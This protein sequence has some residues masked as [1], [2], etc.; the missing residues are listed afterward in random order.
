MINEINAAA[1]AYLERL[2]ISSASLDQRRDMDR[3][4]GFVAGAEYIINS[5]WINV[6]DYLP[7]YN[8]EVIVFGKR[9]QMS[10][11]MGGNPEVITITSRIEI[12]GTRLERTRIK[13]CDDN[14][15]RFME[16]VTHWMRKP[17]KP[18]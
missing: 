6:N 14:D 5:S 17:N 3:R 7:E 12:K 4:K 18:V 1:D 16:Y 2:R 8:E 10:P 9:I 15:F 13:Y 11:Q